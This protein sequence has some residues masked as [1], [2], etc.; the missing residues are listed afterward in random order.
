M[1]LAIDV[2]A[3]QLRAANESTN[4]DLA[5]VDR[6][7]ELAGLFVHNG[8]VDLSKLS[9]E[10]M[11]AKEALEYAFGY[12]YRGFTPT[13]PKVVPSVGG[14]FA[15]VYAP[16][17]WDEY[18]RD[19]GHLP[20]RF[21]YEGRQFGFLGNINRDGG[22][23]DAFIILVWDPVLEAPLIAW[24][25]Y[26][27]GNVSYCFAVRD[28]GFLVIPLWQSSSAGD[29]AAV[30]EG[31]AVGFTFASFAFSA[32]LGGNLVREIGT[33]IV[34]TSFAAANP[35]LTMAIGNTAVGTVLNGGD[36][37]QAAKL[38]AVG[39]VAAGAGAYV[40]GAAAS[41][42]S[43]PVTGKVAEA[44][45]GS[46]ISGGD[47]KMAIARVLVTEGAGKAKSFIDTRKATN[48][49][50]SVNDWAGGIE[51]FSPFGDVSFGSQ[52]GADWSFDQSPL[53]APSVN[54]TFGIPSVFAFAP[55]AGSAGGNPFGDIFGNTLPTAAAP[56]P[57]AVPGA[58][59][60]SGWDYAKEGLKLVPGIVKALKDPKPAGSG[61]VGADGQVNPRAL[62][63]NQPVV[64]PDGRV[65]VRGTDGK[66]TMVDQ[67]GNVMGAGFFGLSPLALGAIGVGAVALF[68]IAR[69]R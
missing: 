61:V 64:L 50:I 36:I 47:P 54:D 48:V 34:G 38:S 57:A 51:S 32:G 6:A 7:R 13:R 24:S 3:A 17:S 8:I 67:R 42:T 62:S 20:F 18:I 1:S 15:T 65:V 9:L 33:K 31:L 28:T 25:S 68:L 58:S 10:R 11:G 60:K 40:G 69:R 2:V 14:T 5:G 41:A 35:L 66:I 23:S 21:N 56:K 39:A 22:Y 27:D 37:E 43:S 53:V 26:G 52:P 46:Y 19:Q 16:I 4:W 45:V 29:K 55:D 30:K 59:G 49:E 44:A 12:D 63:P